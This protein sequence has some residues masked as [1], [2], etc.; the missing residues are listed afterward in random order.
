[1]PQVLIE[2]DPYG[3][4]TFKTLVEGPAASPLLDGLVAYWKLDEAS[5]NA[6]DSVGTNHLVDNNTVKAAAGKVAGARQFVQ[7]DNEFFSIPDN[8]ALSMAPDQAFTLAGW[9]FSELV[10]TNIL[11]S[12]G[13]LVSFP[14]AEY[15]LEGSGTNLLLYVGNGSANGLAT[16]TAV[17]PLSTWVFF[18]ASHD[19][20]GDLLAISINGAAPW[21]AAWAG[22]SYDSAQELCL[23]KYANFGSGALTGRLDEVGIWKRLLSPAE[24]SQ[25]YNG[26]AGLSYPFA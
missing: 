6:Q 4:R 9:F 26:G 3:R 7:A 12:K 23:G 20:V 14:G 10:T 2:V 16:A 21:T 8:A 19:P 22:G 13:N 17:L 25:L 18:A 5:G 1:M 24:I 11:I 15:H